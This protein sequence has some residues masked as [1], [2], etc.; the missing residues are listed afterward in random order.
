MYI[1]KFLDFLSLRMLLKFLPKFLLKFEST[2]LPGFVSKMEPVQWVF[3]MVLFLYFQSLYKVFVCVPTS[4]LRPPFT[5]CFTDVHFD[6]TT[7]QRN[8]YTHDC[9]PVRK[10]YCICIQPTENVDMITWPL[11]LLFDCICMQVVSLLSE[12]SSHQVAKQQEK[13]CQEGRGHR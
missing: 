10:L 4:S 9:R 11:V 3:I 6:R 12:D 1:Y 2:T 8:N 5:L 7:M 13:H